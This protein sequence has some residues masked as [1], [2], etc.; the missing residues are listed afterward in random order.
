MPIS[1][2]LSD[3]IIREIR[4]CHSGGVVAGLSGKMHEAE[5][6]TPGDT[7]ILHN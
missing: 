4:G 1:P 6:L 3:K 2:F 7:L 5:D